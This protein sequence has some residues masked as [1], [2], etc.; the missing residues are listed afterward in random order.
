MSIQPKPDVDFA[1]EYN[2]AIYF[3]M[4]TLTTIGYGDITPQNNISALFTIMLQ[5]M[6]VG[7]FWF[8]YWSSLANDC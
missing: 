3:L 2:L 1:T 6:G 8:G 5:F 7:V 4:T